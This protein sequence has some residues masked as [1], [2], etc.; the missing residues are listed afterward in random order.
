MG[1]SGQDSYKGQV[2]LRK[3]CPYLEHAYK[4]TGDLPG[5][6][7]LLASFYLHAGNPDKAFRILSHAIKLDKELFKDFE[8]LFPDDMLTRKIRKLLN[9]N[10]YNQ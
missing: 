9:D 2:L 8:I 5:I 10:G 6:N 4:I 3:L 7:Y 1:R